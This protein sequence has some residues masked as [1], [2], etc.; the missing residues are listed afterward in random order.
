ML[1]NL[2]AIRKAR[3]MTQK[4]LAQLAKVNRINISQYEIGVKNP[5]LTTVQKLA[6]ALGCT[7]EQLLGTEKAG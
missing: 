3:K 6:S 5:N 2:R 4:E 7:I 1:K